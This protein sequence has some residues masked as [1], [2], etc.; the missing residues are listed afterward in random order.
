MSEK[1]VSLTPEGRARLEAELAQLRDERRP[2]VVQ[3]LHSAREDSE[4]WDNP[5]VQEAKNELAFVD[6][7]IKEL[8]RTLAHAGV[9]EHRGK[10]VVELGAKVT[11]RAAEDGE[12]EEEVYYIVGSAEAQPAEGRISDQSPVGK[13]LLGHRK[14]ERVTVTT[15]AGSRELVIER[16]D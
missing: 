3:R 13:A 5:E 1:L 4:A 2:Q 16:I 6:G 12:E 8:E 10:D 11:L 9:I 15:P 7:R 14:G